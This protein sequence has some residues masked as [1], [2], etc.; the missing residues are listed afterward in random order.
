MKKII[1]LILTLIL[2]LSLASCG[3][4]DDKGHASPTESASLPYKDLSADEILSAT[5]SIPPS[6]FQVVLS[7]DEIE[8]LVAILRTVE[9]DGPDYSVETEGEQTVFTLEM[10][11]GAEK[12]IFSYDNVI[13]LSGTHTVEPHETEVSHTLSEFGKRIAEGAYQQ[14]LEKIANSVYASSG[15]TLN[16]TTGQVVLIMLDENQSLP[17]RWK[18]DVSD[19]S[20]IVL[21]HDEIYLSEA[22]SSDTPGAGGEMHIFYF[23]ALH[24]GECTIEMNLVYG[25]D[26]IAETESYTIRIED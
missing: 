7:D 25:D 9:I 24:S 15:S 11:T 23:E 8:E 26:E 17:G 22:I 14:F 6:G 5:V 21:I 3:N 20:M 19:N 4:G 16:V 1:S 12:S 10:A 18:P 13:Y 2:A